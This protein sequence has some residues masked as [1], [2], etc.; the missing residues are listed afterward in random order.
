MRFGSLESSRLAETSMVV[1]TWSRSLI[2]F[3]SGACLLIMEM[4]K[5]S[6][7]WSRLLL[8]TTALRPWLTWI[9]PL[10]SRFLNASRTER[11]EALNWSASSFW[12]GKSSPALNCLERIISSSLLAMVVD[13]VSVL[14]GLNMRP[15]PQGFL[16]SAHH[17]IKRLVL[18][19]YLLTK[20]TKCREY[21][22]KKDIFIPRC[23]MENG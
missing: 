17:T 3:L 23:S 1:R 9:S 6:T 10:A 12:L 14:K 7:N 21:V 18:H 22:C 8:L 16:N 4:D 11:E 20:C 15:L 13:L 5:D 19:R 2:S